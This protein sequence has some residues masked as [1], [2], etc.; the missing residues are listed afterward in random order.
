MAQ[1]PGRCDFEPDRP[2]YSCAW[3]DNCPKNR[4]HKNRVTFTRAGGTG[5][6]L[7]R[8]FPGRLL[9]RPACR[10]TGQRGGGVGPFAGMSED[11]TPK[12]DSPAKRSVG[13][14]PLRPGA[15][16][17]PAGLIDGPLTNGHC[18]NR[19]AARAGTK[20]LTFTSPL[21]LKSRPH[22][23]KLTL[24]RKASSYALEICER[25][26]LRTFRSQNCWREVARLL[27]ASSPGWDSWGAIPKNPFPHQ[28]EVPF[29]RDDFRV[30]YMAIGVPAAAFTP[31]NAGM[32]I[33]INH[34]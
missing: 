31:K 10:K 6:A 8:Q 15:R 2:L 28:M 4:T 24:L 22:L 34:R 16:L 5:W 32:R 7:H 23:S 14:N 9:L 17:F 30:I 26:L 33:T 29:A 27:S 25:Q 18:G 20:K 12:A 3:D 21:E 13:R 19:A 11:H 1:R